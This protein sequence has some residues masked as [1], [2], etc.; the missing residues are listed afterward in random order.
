[1]T[2]KWILCVNL[3]EILSSTLTTA[4]RKLLGMGVLCNKPV[5]SND[6]LLL[7]F[8]PPLLLLLPF[9]LLLLLL[10]L[11]SFKP[12]EVNAT[13]ALP[14]VIF[15]RGKQS[16]PKLIHPCVV[17]PKNVCKPSTREEL[18]NHQ[19]LEVLQPPVFFA[20][21]KALKKWSPAWAVDSH[22]T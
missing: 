11:L 13:G 4:R 9:I 5:G 10:L 1:M 22:D 2:I 19:Q 18:S 17:L 12:K 16:G 7:L 20:E 21:E 8:R 3:G 15:P 14:Q 6:L